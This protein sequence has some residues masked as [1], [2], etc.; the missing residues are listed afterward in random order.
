MAGLDFAAGAKLSGASFCGNERANC[1]NAPCVLAQFMLDLHTE[2][3]GYTGSLCTLFSEP[4][5]PLWNR[6]LPKFGEDLF[7]I[8]PLEG[9]QPYVLIPTAEVPVTNLVRDEILGCFD[10]R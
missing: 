2:Q 1:E 8:N 5:Y 10:H 9:E 4:C 7:H 3:H 6:Q